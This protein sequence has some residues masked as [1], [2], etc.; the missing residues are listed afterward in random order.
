[1]SAVNVC[2]VSVCVLC[3]YELVSVCV[4]CACVCVYV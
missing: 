4:W 2:G 1:M 3:D